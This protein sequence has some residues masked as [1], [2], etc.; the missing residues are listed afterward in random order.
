[1]INYFLELFTL[2]HRGYLLDLLFYLLFS[3]IV[4]ILWM[5]GFLFSSLH[6]KDQD[7]LL[8]A[9]LWILTAVAVLA[10]VGFVVGSIN[11]F[12]FYGTFGG[13]LNLVTLVVAVALFLFCSWVGRRFNPRK[14]L[15]WLFVPGMFVVS[16]FNVWTFFWFFRM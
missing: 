10:G 13:V 6:A 16:F 2:F 7:K 8:W 14:K 9:T 11:D 1:M 12:S 5:L 15:Q 4:V 3:L